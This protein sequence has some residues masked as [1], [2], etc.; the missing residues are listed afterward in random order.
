[1]SRP[2]RRLLPLAAL[3][4]LAACGGTAPASG[5]PTSASAPTATAA[6]TVGASSP[7]ATSW[8]VVAP[9]GGGFSVEMPGQPTFQTQVAQTALGPLELHLA[10]LVDGEGAYFA[11]WSDYPAG[12]ITDPAASLIG[13][14]DG[15]VTNINGTL[16]TDAPIERAGLPGHSL[17]AT[18]A[19][20]TYQAE[21]LLQGDRMFQMGVASSDNATG[22][23]PERFFASFKLTG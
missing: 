17:T 21:I 7:A 11:S 10:T 20:G 18:V 15:A 1:M 2:I 3:M 16:V 23:D 13:A 19:G 5:V 9:E 14:R 12:S 6:P 22:F 4:L 8:V